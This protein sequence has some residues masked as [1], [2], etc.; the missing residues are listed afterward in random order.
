MRARKVI[1]VTTVREYEVVAGDLDRCD[2][3]AEKFLQRDFSDGSVLPATA[4]RRS[5][6][7]GDY[8]AALGP[9]VETSRELWVT[10]TSGD[11]TGRD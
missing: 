7:G 9:P 10:V 4:T 3:L 5:L 8:I 6:V 1:Q 2:E 11:P